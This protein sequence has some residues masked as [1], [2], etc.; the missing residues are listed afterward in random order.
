MLSTL[1][2][3]LQTSVFFVLGGRNL[4]HGQQIFALQIDD[5]T[6]RSNCDGALTVYRLTSVSKQTMSMVLAVEVQLIACMV[7]CNGS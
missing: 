2:S 5:H 7:D 3:S 1:A 4:I 6:I